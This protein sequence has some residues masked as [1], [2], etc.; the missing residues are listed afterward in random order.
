[1]LMVLQTRA[2]V[3]TPEDS[4]SQGLIASRQHTVISG[5]GEANVSV[6]LTAKENEANLERVVLF[7]GHQ[8]NHAISL[9]T[10]LELEDA[11]IEGGE[12][13]GEIAMEQAFLKCNLDKDNYLVAGL[14]IPRTGIINENHLPTS[15]NSVKRPWVERLVIPSTWRE[16]GIGYYGHSRRWNGLY[17]SLACI[18]GL[19]ASGF[20]A[21]S[22]IRSG[23]QEGSAAKLSGLACHASVLY[24]VGAFRVQTS[25]YYGGSVADNV[26]DSNGQALKKGLLASPVLLNE[27]NLQYRKNRLEIRVLAASVRVRDAAAINSIYHQDVARHFYGAYAEMSYCFYQPASS[28][29]GRKLN[30]F[31]RLEYMDLYAAAAG[32]EQSHPELSRYYGIWGLTYTPCR[33]IIAKVDH[34]SMY[35]GE[36]VSNHTVNLGIGYSF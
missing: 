12:A 27:L 20:S 3:L 21:G 35:T 26:T 2:Q 9:F 19:D 13:G 36:K 33:G 31:G 32:G 7:V 23:R 22:G 4:L 5:Y 25:C 10:E 11:R 15:F 17:Y 1:M 14:F 8:F 30:L 28:A 29:N 6:D 18:N 34:T 16:I 24:Y